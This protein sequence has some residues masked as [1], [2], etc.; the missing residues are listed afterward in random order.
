MAALAIALSTVIYLIA[1]LDRPHKGTLRLSR[2]AMTELHRTFRPR[3][4]RARSRI[5]VSLRDL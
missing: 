2:E 4:R 3:Q 5:P 1:D